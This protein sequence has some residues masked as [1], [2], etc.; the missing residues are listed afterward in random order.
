[1][2]CTSETAARRDGHCVKVPTYNNGTQ[3]SSHRAPQP[4]TAA[5]HTAGRNTRT[6]TLSHVLLSNDQLT[7]VPYS[8]ATTMSLNIH[9]G[10]ARGYLIPSYQHSI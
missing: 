8:L 2:G 5:T 6:A 9:V 3:S 4:T 10:F 1:M 7:D